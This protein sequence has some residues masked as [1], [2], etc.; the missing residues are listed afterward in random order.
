MGTDNKPTMLTYVENTPEQLAYNIAHSKELTKTLVDLY[1]GKGY[2]NIW[3]IACGSSNN[4][5]QCAKPFMMKYLG[6]DVK[7]VPPNSFIY[8][9]FLFELLILNLLLLYHLQHVS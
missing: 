3:I 4:G 2:K 9:I 5:C 7:I 1:V 8:Q 6:V